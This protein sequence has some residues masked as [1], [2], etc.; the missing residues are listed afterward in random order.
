MSARERSAAPDTMD[1][2]DTMGEIQNRGAHERIL[3]MNVDLTVVGGRVM[4]ERQR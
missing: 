1:T 2:M 3:D 4:F